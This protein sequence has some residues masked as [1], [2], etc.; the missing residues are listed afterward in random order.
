MGEAEIT[1]EK[2]R[3]RDHWEN[4]KYIEKSIGICGLLLGRDD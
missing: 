4:L 1:R 2:C 3:Y